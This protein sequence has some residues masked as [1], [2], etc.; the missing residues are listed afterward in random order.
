MAGF[1][2]YY[3]NHFAA[4]RKSETQD[5]GRLQVEPRDLETET[6]KCEKITSGL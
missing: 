6:P 1:D 2:V 5:P 4:Y 3:R